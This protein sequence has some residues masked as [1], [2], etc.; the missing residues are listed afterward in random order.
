MNQNMQWQ[1]PLGSIEANHVKDLS[2]DKRG[3]VLCGRKPLVFRKNSSA[4]FI[5]IWPG[6]FKGMV[7]GPTHKHTVFMFVQKDLCCNQ[8]V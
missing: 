7:N 2:P 6:L 1:E 8:R 3:S 4:Y 5:F